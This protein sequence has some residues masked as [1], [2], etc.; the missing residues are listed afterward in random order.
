MSYSA[1]QPPDRLQPLRFPELFFRL[2]VPADIAGKDYLKIFIALMKS[3]P[4]TSIC[5]RFPSA[6]VRT[7]FASG[8]D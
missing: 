1:D 6:R 8:T 4:G 2:P 5:R 7:K 3:S